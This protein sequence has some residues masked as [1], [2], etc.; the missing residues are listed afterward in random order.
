M[1]YL[2]N[3]VFS[4]R[5]LQIKYPGNLFV[6]KYSF[7]IVLYSLI[8]DE[9]LYFIKKEEFT[10]LFKYLKLPDSLCCGISVKNLPVKFESTNTLFILYFDILA[11]MKV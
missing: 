2:L 6:K 5:I 9:P 4:K 11:L 3:I 7:S 1:L 10:I 8:Q